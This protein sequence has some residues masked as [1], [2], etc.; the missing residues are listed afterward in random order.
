MK[1]SIIAIA[2]LIATGSAFA[3]SSSVTLYGIADVGIGNEKASGG[4]STSKM[5]NGSLKTSRWGMRGSEDLGS[6]LKAN[7]KFEQRLDLSNGEVQSPS[8]K[9]EASVGLSG[10]FGAVT[11]GRFTTIY[12]DVRAVGIIS[13]LWDS[14]FTPTNDVYKAA[15]GDYSSRFN[16]Q[17]RYATPTFGGFYAAVGYAFEQ[18][19]GAD[20]TMVGVKLGYKNG[21]LHVAL[22]TQKQKAKDDDYI[23]LSGNYDFGA[24]SVSAGYNTRRGT[25]ANGDDT[26]LTVGVNVPVGAFDL[27]IGYANAKTKI[28]DATSAKASGF[29]LGATYKMSK[30]TRLYAGLKDLDFKDGSGN[31]TGDSRLFALGIRH[32]F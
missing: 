22:G 15:G 29:G 21:P 5:V 16:S 26:E 28:G 8:F 12:D 14:S 19:A 23:A 18:T 25:D 7:F 31:K 6:G 1:H 27:S 9:G 24:A 10:G 13:N 11:L 17:I 3:Q 4:S 20:D 2:T 30:R 32:D